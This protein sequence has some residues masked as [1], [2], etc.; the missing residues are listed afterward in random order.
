VNRGNPDRLTAIDR[1]GSY[2]GSLLAV[3][4][5]EGGRNARPGGTGT[6]G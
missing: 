2:V 6:H 1:S 3:T 4:K 5:A